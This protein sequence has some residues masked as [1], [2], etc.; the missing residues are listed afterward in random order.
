MSWLWQPRT[1]VV[2]AIAALAW[3]TAAELPPPGVFSNDLALH[4]SLTGG[5]VEHRTLDFW[6]TTDLGYPTLRLYQPLYHL[7]LA[8]LDGASG[9]RIGLDWWLQLSVASLAVFVPLSVYVGLRRWLQFEGRP[10]AE[11]GWIAA[12]AVA[13]AVCARSFSGFGFDPLQSVA[14]RFGVIT[15]TWSMVFFVPAFAWAHGFVSGR[16]RSPWPAL[17][18]SF[19]TAGLSLIVGALL[20]A[21][22]AVRALVEAL[23]GRSLAVVRRGAVYFAGVAVVTGFLWYPMVADVPWVY[24]PASLFSPWVN[25]GFGQSVALK[26]LVGGRVFDGR[27]VDTLARPPVMTALF[28]L[29]AA[30]CAGL[31]RGAARV[32]VFLV[33]GWLLWFSLF[34]GRGAWGSLLYLLPLVRSFQWGRFEALVQFW[35]IAMAAAGLYALTSLAWHRGR[36]RTRTAARAAVVIAA[37]AAV[38]VFAHDLKRRA[39]GNARLLQQIRAGS[40]AERVRDIVARL[41]GDPNRT[42]VGGPTTWEQRVKDGDTWLGVA[43]TA[44]GVPTVGRIYQGMNVAAS[45][46]HYWD[47]KSPWGARLLSV[48]NWLAPCAL[49][50]ELDLIGPAVKVAPTVC[51]GLSRTPPAPAF[52]SRLAAGRPRALTEAELQ[53]LLRQVVKAP[54]RDVFLPFALAA[55]AEVTELPAE[56]APLP[57]VDVAGTPF[58]AVAPGQHAAR[59]RLEAPAPGAV[60]FPVSFHPRLRATVDGR[61]ARP[62]PVL[63]GYAAVPVSAGRHEVELVY[64]TDR[65]KDLLLATAL[66]ALIAGPCIARLRQRSGAG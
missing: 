7:A 26:A 66:V 36:A 53:P 6:H 50:R 65:R 63:P 4:R 16:A 54:D 20:F 23:A 38:V 59:V 62:R 55:V 14:I 39:A 1:V 9:G 31:W 24:Y 47:G 21:S 29:G 49:S 58:Q 41:G 28:F 15:Q 44:R 52:F 40:S 25:E 3:C 43:L 12:T 34:I 64:R 35:G 46:Q 60:V 13:L 19:L 61:A 10:A 51:L 30:A 27:N 57:P 2:V 8:L 56:L 37:A 5:L 48:Q 11:A 22:V 42:Y 45:L 32:R 17:G 33:A 18:L